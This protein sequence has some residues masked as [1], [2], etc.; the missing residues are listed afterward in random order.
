MNGPTIKEVVKL[1]K[2]TYGLRGDVG[3]MTEDYLETLKKIYTAEL[4]FPKKTIESLLKFKSMGFIQ[5]IVTSTSQNLIEE[6]LKRSG[7]Y[8]IFDGY[9]FGNE[10]THS[11]P[12]PEIY[13]KA[14]S[15]SGMPPSELLVIED[16]V[17]GINSAKA[18]GLS[19]CAI[20]GTHD[21][22]FLKNTLADFVICEIEEIISINE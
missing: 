9:V 19:V 10:V 11:K 6:F 12:N 18:A 15:K 21:K 17:N 3:Q 8:G 2:E 1:L 20:A 13:L 14:I 16:A 5:F 22:E 7:V 4:D